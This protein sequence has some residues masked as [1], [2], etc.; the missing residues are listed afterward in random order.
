MQ[1]KQTKTEKKIKE[2]GHDKKHWAIRSKDGHKLEFFPI[3][4]AN[5]DGEVQCTHIQLRFTDEKG[6]ERT[7]LFNYLDIY[8]FMYFTANEELRRNLAARHE[9]LTN[10]IPYDVQIKIS[11]D[12]KARGIANRRIELPVDEIT[13]AIAR[14]EAWKLWIKS[15]YKGNPKEFLYRKNK[16][17]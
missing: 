5:E 9:R 1:P 6:N 13:M 14:N 4:E 7:M 15:Q 10:Y 8:M 16:K 11:D 3:F 2:K 17:K 12:E